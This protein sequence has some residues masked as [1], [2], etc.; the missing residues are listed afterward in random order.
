[1]DSVAKNGYVSISE[2]SRGNTARI[3]KALS[4][5]KEITVLKNN[6]PIGILILPQEK[7]GTKKLRN[8]GTV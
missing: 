3:F 6:Q 2:F 5:K 7:K 8:Q 4:D 1:M